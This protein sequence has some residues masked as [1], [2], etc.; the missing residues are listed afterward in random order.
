MNGRK[1]YEPG[2]T[3]VKANMGSSAAPGG[4]M[5]NNNSPY[6]MTPASGPSGAAHKSA[7]YSDDRYKMLEAPC[8]MDRGKA[9]TRC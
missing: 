3:M 6:E 9:E 8:F 1:D 4:D 5:Y 7:T 2:N